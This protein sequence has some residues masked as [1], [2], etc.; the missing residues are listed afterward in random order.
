MLNAWN[1][2]YRSQ[3]QEAGPRPT[4]G[5]VEKSRCT[6]GPVLR[7]STFRG[8][9]NPKKRIQRAPLSGCLEFDDSSFQPDRYGVRPV[10]GAQFG[11][12]VFDVPFH[13]FF[14]NGELGGDLLVGIP[15]GDQAENLYFPC[16]K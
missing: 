8:H 7:L 4:L 10:V 14:R 5:N 9:R 16:G 6:K 3:K 12:D 2:C 15:T 13:G 11:E 1:H